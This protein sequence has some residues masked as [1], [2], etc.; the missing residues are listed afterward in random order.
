MI[1]DNKII[2][3][4]EK[5]NLVRTITMAIVIILFFCF[6]A[7]DHYLDILPNFLHYGFLYGRKYDCQNDQTYWD[8]VFVAYAISLQGYYCT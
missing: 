1:I 4:Y 8:L 7:E 5:Y 6:S 2:V 3:I